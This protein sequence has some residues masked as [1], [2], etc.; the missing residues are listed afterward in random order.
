MSESPAPLR[1]SVITPTHNRPDSLL[2]LLRALRD[3]TCPASAF[4]AVIVADGCNDDTVIRARAEPL[5]FPVRVLEQNPGRGAAAARN[6]GATVAAGELLVFLDDD[7][8]PFPALLAEH[9]REYQ[10]AKTPTAVVGPPRPVHRTNAGLQAIAGWSW[11]EQ[12]FAMMQRPGH[13][14]TYDNLFSGNLSVPRALF[15]SVGG[16]DEEFNSCRDD[17]EFGLRLIRQGARIA[18]APAAGAWHHELRDTIALRRR[19]QAEGIA[20]VRL[21]RLYPEL[22]PALNLALPDRRRSRVYDAVRRVAFRSPRIGSTA[23][24][25]LERALPF[26]EGL[27]MRGTWRTVQRGLMHYAYWQGVARAVGSYEAFTSLRRDCL[28]RAVDAPQHEIDLAQ[29]LESAAQALEAQQPLSATIRVGSQYVGRIA[30]HAGAEPLGARH[31]RAALAGDLAPPLKSALAAARTTGPPVLTDDDVPAVSV[32]IPAFNAAETL[33]ATLDSVLAQTSSRWEAIVVDDGSTDDTAVVCARYAARDDRIRLVRQPNGGEA[34][35]RNTGLAG[36]RFDWVLFLDADDWLLPN[37]LQT[38]ARAARDDETLDVITGGWSRVAADGT[39]LEPEYCNSTDDVFPVFARHNALPIHGAIVR[40]AALPLEPFDPSLKTCADWDFWQRLARAAVKFGRVQEVVAHYR[41]RAGSASFAIESLWPDGL[42]VIAQGHAED[43]RVANARHMQGAPNEQLSDARFEFA[44]WVGGLLIG[45]DRDPLALLRDLGAERDPGL[46]PEIVALQLFQTVPLATARSPAAWDELWPKVSAAIAT[47]LAAVE[48]TASAPLFARRA[49]CHL[50][51]LTLDAS[52]LPR[53]FTRGE[54]YAVDVDVSQPVPM[55]EGANGVERAH[56]RVLADGARIGI[57]LVAIGAN[58]ATNR[59]VLAEEIVQQYAWPILGW[60]LRGGPYQELA[61]LRA[62]GGLTVTRE[63]VTLAT[64]LADTEAI[65][66]ARLHDRIGWTV[67]LQELWDRRHWSSDEFYRDQRHEGG[68]N[69]RH[70]DTGRLT[71]DVGAELPSLSV[72]PGMVELALD[73]H[74]G[75][76]PLGVVSIPV[77]GDAVGPAAIRA[78]ITLQTSFALCR[79]AVREGVLGQPRGAGP[80]HARLAA[81]F[82]AAGQGPASSRT[83]PT[84]PNEAQT[85]PARPRTFNRPHFESVFAGR[86]DPWSYVTPYEEA[87]AEETPSLLP[88]GSIPRVMRGL[89]ADSLRL[90]VFILDIHVANGVEDVQCNGYKSA[91]A[92]IRRRGVPL[93]WVNLSCPDGRIAAADI[94]A[95]VRYQLGAN[96]RRAVVMDTLPV[97]SAG[98]LP[99][100]SV[101]V[102]T[103]DRHDLL[104]RCLQ[105]LAKLDYPT[106][107][108]VVVDNASTSDL[109]RQVAESAHVRYAHE[110]IPG[111]NW[112]RN[113]GFATARHE[114]IAFIDDDVEVDPLWLRGI[115]AGFEDGSVQFV[116]GLVAPARM[117]TEAELV[118]E[119]GYGGMGKGTLPRRWDPALLSSRELIGAH[120]LGVGAN[121]AF[122]RP[123]LA[124]LGGFDPGLDVG[125]AAHGAGDLDI[126]HRALMGG[127]V[128]TYEP[129]ALVRHHHRRDMAALRRQHYDNGRAFGVFLLGILKRGEIPRRHTAWYTL[130]IWLAWLVRRLFSSGRQRDQLP[131]DLILAELRGAWHAPWA[132]FATRRE[133]RQRA[134]Q[135]KNEGFAPFRPRSKLSESQNFNSELNDSEP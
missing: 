4:E 70:A 3:G 75:G 20:D 11:W 64:G 34:V 54:T 50:E 16:F 12:Q 19:K 100:I 69:L 72:A 76:A 23:A 79:L 82:A 63:R 73:V 48:Q 103:R 53:P 133:M 33:G 117:D 88:E 29:G 49:M 51:R 99:P 56:C 65:D 25:A 132:Y 95:A 111:L 134:A 128:G 123:L 119:L 10:R 6:L 7:I 31:L 32:V 66:A 114:I 98:S 96:A 93:G 27:R 17:S 110:P 135:N 1:M 130:R 8:E 68:S 22:W 113:R 104:E 59:E 80:L 38:L 78:A 118:F 74:V 21:A 91:R 121:M 107:E 26:F 40:R 61:F 102:C 85:D 45:Q 122:R 36:A 57:V 92:L 9:W 108:V 120:H 125:T 116:T 86:T 42:R 109:T 28:E 127:A 46:D 58:T 83:F 18:F 129:R 112:A 37:A 43:L 24:A 126:F 94:V 115:A 67:F 47:F 60:F 52:E 13:R 5:P 35:A 87:E 97:K 62:P 106:Y 105:S 84:L 44:C 90:P 81:R 89:P 131:G 30:P 124:S 55:L 15:S 41:M 77:S 2:R 71:I 39:V 14:F 101:V